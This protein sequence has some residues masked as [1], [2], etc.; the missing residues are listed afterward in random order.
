[1]ATRL[2]GSVGRGDRYFFTPEDL[3]IIGLDTKDSEEH[4]L[5]DERIKLPVHEGMV[6]SIKVYGVIEDVVVRKNGPACEVVDGRQRVRAARQANLELK[7]DGKAEVRIPVTTRKGDDGEMLGVSVATNEQRTADSPIVRAKKAQ[8][9][10]DQGREKPY[11]AMSFGVSQVV[12]NGLLALLEL[13][14]SVQKAVEA[15]ELSVSAAA[16]LVRL[17]REDQRAKLAEVREKA[18]TTG[19]RP[20]AKDTKQAADPSAVVAPSKARIR[21]VCDALPNSPERDALEWVLG[22]ASEDG[23]HATMRDAFNKVDGCAA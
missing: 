1:M 12:L 17:K 3:I 23:Y 2:E 22:R 9:M 13:D 6:A 7:R 4:A 18:K 19:K 10:L 20:T 8:K 15:G 11:V 14:R 21:A 16:K 5:Y